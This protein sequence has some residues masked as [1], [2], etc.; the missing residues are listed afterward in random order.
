MADQTLDF[1][2]LQAEKMSARS[3]SSSSA[4]I[5]EQRNGA[6]TSQ[7]LE[8]STSHATQ[9]SLQ[10]GHPVQKAIT[11]QDWTGPDDEENPMNWAI[12]KKVYHVAIPAL[13]CFTMYVPTHSN[14]ELS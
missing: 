8:K 2:E 3:D 5:S 14:Q 7:D 10:H 12:W 9:H 6:E 11:A 13:Q 1:A 4:S